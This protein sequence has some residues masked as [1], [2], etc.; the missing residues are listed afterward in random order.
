MVKKETLLHAYS[1]MSLARAMA[2]IYDVNR[3]I[4]KNI[5]STSKEHDATKMANRLILKSSDY[6]AP[7]CRD[8]A[9]LLA[10][11][12]TPYELMLQLLAKKDDPFSGG[13]TY[14]AH[15]SLN[16]PDMPKMPHQSS[17]T[18]MQAIPATGMA[19]GLSYLESRGLLVGVDKQIGRAHV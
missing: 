15:P 5:K 11:G 12:M 8:E 16:R 1:L 3:Q 7:Y 4:T 14:Y 10:M 9:M 17:A 13:R 19:H 2:D 6:A 18:G